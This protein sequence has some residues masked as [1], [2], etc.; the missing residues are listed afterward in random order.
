MKKINI[1]IVSFIIIAFIGFQAMAETE[2]RFIGGVAAQTSGDLCDLPM[3]GW[4]AGLGFNLAETFDYVLGF[5]ILYQQTT[6]FDLSSLKGTDSLTRYNLSAGVEFLLDLD[7]IYLGVGPGLIYRMTKNGSTL[8]DSQYGFYCEFFIPIE[9]WRWLTVKPV[10]TVKSFG[11]LEELEAEL[12]AR[13]EVPVR[14]GKH[15]KARAVKRS[16]Y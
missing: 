11:I 5:R 10:A 4:E 6:P 14:L 8:I 12:S 7:S 1:I 16:Q 2:V 13:V 9:I 15:K 3:A